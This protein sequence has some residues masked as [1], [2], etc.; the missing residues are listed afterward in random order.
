MSTENKE[1]QSLLSE[2]LE[3]ISQIKQLKARSAELSSKIVQTGVR[4]A[5]VLAI[6]AR[7]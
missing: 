2:K 3:L 5:S 1:V 6:V 4:D 7:W